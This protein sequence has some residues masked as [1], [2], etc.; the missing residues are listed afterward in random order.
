MVLDKHKYPIYSSFFLSS[1]INSK[2]QYKYPKNG[3]ETSTTMLKYKT[4]VTGKQLVKIDKFY[5]SSKT[6]SPCGAIKQDL[7]L[8]DRVY[9]CQCGN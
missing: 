4:E 1:N 7:K 5:L 9:I 3:W 6:C 8:S 2:I